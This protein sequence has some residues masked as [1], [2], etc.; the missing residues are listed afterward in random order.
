M[1]PERAGEPSVAALPALPARCYG[2]SATPERIVLRVR[3]LED[4]NL[5]RAIRLA[6]RLA[7]PLVPVLTLGLPGA[8]AF[9]PGF[10]AWILLWVCGLGFITRV[11]PF[12]GAVLRVVRRSLVIDVPPEAGYRDEGEPLRLTFD[13]RRIDLHAARVALGRLHE[14]GQR[15]SD[16]DPWTVNLVLSNGLVRVAK[17]R[18]E[19]TARTLAEWLAAVLGIA[20]DSA[21][22]VEISALPGYPLDWKVGLVA[23]GHAVVV[24]ALAVFAAVR[25]TAGA[26]L[27]GAPIVLALDFC[28]FDVL[29]G[30]YLRSMAEGEA[31]VSFRLGST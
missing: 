6:L 27:A 7:V 4:R 8:G 24:A 29:L 14:P 13:G 5:V 25:G 11:A 30:R 31:R 28:V 12:Q 10:T 20:H 16:W 26:W 3:P 2:V 9:V 19:A 17:L 21:E 18:R 15:S 22:V 1:L 23:F